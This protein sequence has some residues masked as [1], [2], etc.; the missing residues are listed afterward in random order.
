MLACEAVADDG[1]DASILASHHSLVFANL[2]L[3]IV[4]GIGV[5]RAE[6]SP[7]GSTH[8]LVGIER[9]NVH[10]VEVAVDGV[11]HVEVLCHLKVVLAG[12]LCRG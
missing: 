6:H 2:V 4:F 9:V 3:G 10:K 5:E 7:Y 12:I 8:S 1:A 11:E